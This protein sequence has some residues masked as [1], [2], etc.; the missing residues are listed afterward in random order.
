MLHKKAVSITFKRVR[1]SLHFREIAYRS[2]LYQFQTQ[3][4]K[5]AQ[6]FQKG[7]HLQ[8]HLLSWSSKETWLSRRMKHQL[9]GG[10]HAI[11]SPIRLYDQSDL[12][13]T[14]KSDEGRKTNNLPPLSSMER[15]VSNFTALTLLRC[16]SKVKLD[17]SN[18]KN[19]LGK[20]WRFDSSTYSDIRHL[21]F[22]FDRPR[23]LIFSNGQLLAISGTP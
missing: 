19:L 5:Q 22:L 4:R 15:S 13:T 17:N 11:P 20:A 12:E 10:V 2:Q 23:D 18:W 21:G 16:P 7:F 6:G 3:Q 9:F 14:S 8:H 1:T